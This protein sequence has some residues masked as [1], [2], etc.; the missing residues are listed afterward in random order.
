MELHKALAK[1][2]T[3]HGVDTM[4][5]VIGDANM[6]FAHSFADEPSTQYIGATNE[7][8]AV[9]MAFGYASKSG[10]LG[11]AT[12]TRGPGLSNTVTGLIEAVKGRIPLLLICGDT[13]RYSRGNPQD[14][15]QRDLVV[16]T[17]AGF[18][19]LRTPLTGLTDLAIAIRR[20]VVERRPIVFNVVPEAMWAD[21]S[22]EFVQKSIGATSTQPD[23]ISLDTAL[24]IIA[25]CRRPLVVAGRGA[26][27]ARRA[28]VKLAERI[29]APLATS[30]GGKDLFRGEDFDLGIM[31]TLAH[32][33]ALQTMLE[34]DCV[35]AF[36]I[37]LN[38]FTTASRSLTDGKAIVH[39]DI[40]ASLIGRHTKVDAAVAGDASVVAGT[41]VEWLDAAEIPPTSF[42]T[43]ELLQRLRSNE[44]TGVAGSAAGAPGTVDL[45]TALRTIDEMVPAQRIFATDA[46]RYIGTSWTQI[47]VEDPN[48]FVFAVNF[49]AIGLGVAA[50]IGA[51]H[52]ALDQPVLV[53]CGDGG[54]MLGG[55]AE[56]S[57][58]VRHQID[59]ICVVC[60][61]GAYGAELIQLQ[62]RGLPTDLARF[63]WPDLAPL[64]EAMGG[65]GITVR[66]HDDLA[67]AR[68][69][70]EN[71]DRPLLI[72]LKIDPDHVPAVGH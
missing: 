6:F 19:Q 38:S 10:R 41:L 49:G 44:A 21:V 58:A 28:L 68:T 63:S 59:L 3:A 45:L 56:F 26:V 32:E 14:I 22:Y 40:D 70:I 48:D 12:V 31:G 50:G 42:R 62:D 46:G 7:A 35:L 30:L 1:S 25:S 29:G 69:A 11:V 67:A 24:G 36:G 57:T 5:G 27:A 20:A 53:V 66:S 54:F 61:D 34:A 55:L 13:E 72:D 33:A 18:E 8:G 60:N 23:E 17:G 15:P 43:P 47:H 64:A 52:A 2:L 16:S 51:A 71:R 65:S 37:G 4:F 39:C 9:M